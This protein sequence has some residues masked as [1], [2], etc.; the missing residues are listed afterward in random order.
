MTM[1]GSGRARVIP[2]EVT[3]RSSMASSRADC[4][5]GLARFISSPTTM[6]AK[7]GPALNVLDENMP[8]SAQREQDQLDH[9]ALSLYHFLDVGRDPVE[10][11]AE[12]LD[13]LC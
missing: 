2:S 4:V 8:F 13:L 5:L 11:F 1:K 10:P 3:C 12:R 7:I 9:V 6:L